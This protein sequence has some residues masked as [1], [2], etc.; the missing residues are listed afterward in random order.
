[1]SRQHFAAAAAVEKGLVPVTGFHERMLGVDLA[2]TCVWIN[3]GMDR[4]PHTFSSERL[5]ASE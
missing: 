1:M 3:V 5:Q 4:L 2:R